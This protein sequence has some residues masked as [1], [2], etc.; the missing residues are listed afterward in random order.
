MQSTAPYKW[1]VKRSEHGFTLENFIY[2]QLGNWS[3]KQ[4]KDAID[5]KRAF[6][7]GRNAFIS[8]WN[9]KRND[10][11]VFAPTAGDAPSTVTEGGR[12]KFVD[13][14]FEDSAVI[15]ANKPAFV[16][17][18]AFA[19]TIVG[20]L[21]RQNKI[22]S[23][24]YLGQ[25]HRLDRETSGVMIFTKKKVANTL[26][27]QFREHSIRKFYLAIVDGALPQEQGRI[28]KTIEKG[29]FDEGKKVRIAEDE[30]DGKRAETLYRVVERYENASTLQVEIKTGRTHQIRIH[31]SDLGF[32][33]IGDKLYGREKNGVPFRRQALH[34]ERLEFTHPLTHAKMKVVA[35][36]PKDMADL[37]NRLRGIDE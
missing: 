25:L 26:A 7:N 4:V 34:A 37:I 29:E 5:K 30:S 1:R 17:H 36:V 8:N 14:L 22:K 11:V 12:Y 35:P 3:H 13:V 15:A 33:I 31:L 20:Y 2:K 21:K 9:L 24:P 23:F 19:Q 10:L 28:T 6:I 16:D 32:P 18:E 27:D